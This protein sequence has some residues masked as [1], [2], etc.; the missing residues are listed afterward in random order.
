MSLIDYSLII[1]LAVAFLLIL[2]A[3]GF[4]FLIRPIG[5]FPGSTH[6]VQRFQQRQRLL[7]RQ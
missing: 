2:L 7:Q 1:W 3:D 4:H 5:G 6:P